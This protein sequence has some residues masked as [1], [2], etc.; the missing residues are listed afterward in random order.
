MHG[1]AP[2]ECA[3]IGYSSQPKDQVYQQ[4]GDVYKRLMH[5]IVSMPI[6]KSVTITI[7]IITLYHGCNRLANSSCN[8]LRHVMMQNRVQVHSGASD[9]TATPT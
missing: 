8:S 4:P 6:G 5:L 1:D 7:Q 3:A 2:L 9:L